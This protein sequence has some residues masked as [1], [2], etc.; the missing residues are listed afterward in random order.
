MADIQLQNLTKRWGNFTGLKPMDLHIG[1]GEFLVLLGPS[2]CG[3]TTTMRMIAGLEDASEGNI[4]IGGKRVND[5]E[6]KDRDI[7][8]VFQSYGLYP[9]MTV[10][11]NIRFPLKVRGIPEAE[12]H[13]RVMRA[14]ETVELTEFLQRKPAALSGGQRQRV[15]LARAIVRKPKV[16]L[17]DE[18]L[19]NLDAKLRVS[20]RAQI[21][22]LHHELKTTT[23]YVTHD[24]IEAMTLADRVV[25]MSRGEVQQVGTPLEIYDRPANIFVASFIGNPAMNLMEGT[26]K[27]G[28]FEAA[29]VRIPGLS[30]PDGPVTLGFRAEDASIS[31][32]GEIAA[33]IYS[34]ELLGDASMATVQA[35]GALVAVKAAKDY[36]GK[37][38]QNIAAHIPAHICH[39]F[40]AK[41]GV[42]LNS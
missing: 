32:T 37:I 11:E 14:A 18:P 8:M 25:V 38:G 4:L 15:A 23:I 26:L 40:D 21:K 33:P 3:K 17:M 42:R 24:Q 10:Y 2:G 34:M 22:N 27:A 9:T 20:T 41:S 5:L 12:H 29:N 35:G 28:V 1:D 13:D 7:A 30:G 39:L 6:P 16:F 36:T 19:S 31:A